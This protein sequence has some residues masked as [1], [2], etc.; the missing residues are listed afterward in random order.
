MSQSDESSE[1]GSG[2]IK[3]IIEKMSSEVL[4]YTL[5]LI[6]VI[7]TVTIRLNTIDYKLISLFILRLTG[8]R[9]LTIYSIS[10][11][12]FSDRGYFNGDVI[13]ANC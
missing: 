3:S 10:V 8:R 2:V 9:N 4:V 12:L 7:A 1:K 13:R 6:L 11:F 5:T